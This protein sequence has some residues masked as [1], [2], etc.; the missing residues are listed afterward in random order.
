MKAH[1]HKLMKAHFHKLMKA[2]LRNHNI[3]AQMKTKY[4]SY[5]KRKI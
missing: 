4:F 3:K 1:F 2:Y 5:T